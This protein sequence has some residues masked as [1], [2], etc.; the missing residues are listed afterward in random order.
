M[1]IY[2]I[3]AAILD[4]I[5]TET[6]DIIDIERLESLE[7]EREKKISNIACWVKDLL[8]EAAAIKTEKMNLAKRQASCEHKAAQLKS[9]LE[10][11]LGGMKFK[12]ARCSISYRKS[13]SVDVM[14]VDSLPEEFVKVEKT[15]KLTELKEALKNGKDI[16]GVS[17]LQ[18]NHIQIK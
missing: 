3:D 1:T 8:A 7:M 2:E 10:Y 11:A 5:D 14:D 15:A 18:S 17:L 12:D 4:C 13:E 6:G 16:P 9:Y